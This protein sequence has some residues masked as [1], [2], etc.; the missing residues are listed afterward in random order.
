MWGL[1]SSTLL[2]FW[3]P[4]AVWPSKPTFLGYWFIREYAPRGTVGS[5]HSV[6]FT[7]AGDA[8]ADFGFWG[9]ILFWAM[10][11]Y[12]IVLIERWAAVNIQKR[13]D[14]S[15]RLSAAFLYPAAFFSVRSLNTAALITVSAIGVFFLI[16]LTIRAT[17]SPV[18]QSA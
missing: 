13:D 10:M 1:S 18:Q 3:V 7:F 12:P 17:P 5:G 9:G 4:R 16:R 15:A 8:F 11:G 6:S 14:W 2:M